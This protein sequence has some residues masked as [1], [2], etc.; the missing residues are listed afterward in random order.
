M[1]WRTLRSVGFTVVALVA[2]GIATVAAAETAEVRAQELIGRPA[3]GLSVEEVLAGPAREEWS[4]EMLAGRVVVID[5]WSTW[6]APCVEDMPRWNAMVDELA[7]EPVVFAAVS[8]EPADVVEKLLAERRLAGWVAV[9]PGGSVFEAFAVNSRPRAVLIDAEGVVRGVGHTGE[10]TPAMVRRLLAGEEPG[11]VPAPG[12][13]ELLVEIGRS[14]AAEAIYQVGLWPTQASRGM[15]KTGS[16]G[17]VATGVGV[18]TM[19]PFLWRVRAARVVVEDDVPAGRF[20]LVVRP[21]G[22]AER[23]EPLARE[24]L[25]TGLGLEVR[26]EVREVDAWVLRVAE[27][28]EGGRGGAGRCGFARRRPR[29]SRASRWGRASSWGPGRRSSRWPACSKGSCAGRWSTRRAS[30]ASTPWT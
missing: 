23:V 12:V 25:E 24:A 16:D 2:A 7:G 4:A 26:H 11:L 27:L 21:A 19:V 14:E 20:D 22:D 1:Q 13:D 3:P 5:F 18:K 10:V 30:K 17:F 28:G 6:C 9:D 29:R 8:D 15:V